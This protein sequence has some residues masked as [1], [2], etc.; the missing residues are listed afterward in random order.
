[1]H[2]WRSIDYIFTVNLIVDEPTRWWTN[3]PTDPIH[4]ASFHIWTAYTLL[5]GNYLHQ[6]LIKL[7]SSIL[8]G[9][10][11]TCSFKIRIVY[12]IIQLSG[13]N[14][15]YFWN[16]RTLNQVVLLWKDFSLSTRIVLEIV[17]VHIWTTGWSLVSHLSHISFAI[18]KFHMT[19]I[20][21]NNY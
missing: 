4:F 19:Q 11:L 18:W 5:P 14:L 6:Y 21:G 17:F 12:V 9:N 7:V 16:W 20:L 3:S 13:S 1:M 8:P 10:N 15:Y 2:T